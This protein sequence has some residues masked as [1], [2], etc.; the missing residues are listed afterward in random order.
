MHANNSDEVRL[1]L[2]EEN[3]AMHGLYNKLR[4]QIHVNVVRFLDTF[5]AGAK[6]IVVQ[7]IPRDE[8]S[9]ADI[10]EK[11]QMITDEVKIEWESQILIALEFLHSL[12]GNS[13]CSNV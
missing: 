8:T 9:L 6:R 13:F 2:C 5:P 10:V 11:Q 7:E 4:Y 3:D 1:I 12:E